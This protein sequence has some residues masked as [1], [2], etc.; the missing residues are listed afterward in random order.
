MMKPVKSIK[1]IG[2]VAR[3]IRSRQGLRQDDL[4]F[5]ASCSHKFV[6]DVERGKPTIQTGKLLQ[7]LEELGIGIVLDIPDD[8]KEVVELEQ[9][10]ER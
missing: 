4:G 2:A 8:M 7:L 10:G 6:I 5:M 1:E 3:A 9:A